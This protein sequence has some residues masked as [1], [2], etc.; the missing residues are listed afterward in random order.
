V[1]KHHTVSKLMR[2][3]TKSTSMSSSK[4]S[5]AAATAKI[6]ATNVEI[7]GVWMP[8]E[9]IQNRSGCVRVIML[10]DIELDEPANGAIWDKSVEAAATRFFD[11]V[12]LCRKL[13]V[14][15]P[16]PGRAIEQCPFQQFLKRDLYSRAA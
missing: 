7:A 13:A 10:A 6:N 15:L 5:T 9:Y 16:I 11:R 2:H 12:G 14:R 4:Q 3:I 8:C 1:T